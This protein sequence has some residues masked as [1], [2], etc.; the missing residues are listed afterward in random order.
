MKDLGQ[1][2]VARR[3]TIG[4]A[5]DGDADRVGFVDEKG[6]P[7]SSDIIGALL[8]RSVL[9][10]QKG[11][12]IVYDVRSSHS[13]L[14][15]IE[16]NGGTAVREKVG[17]I[18]IRSK[19]RE[20]DA[21][22]GIE[23]SGHFFF[24]ESRFSEGGSLPVFYILDLIQTEQKTLSQLVSEVSKYAHS[25][26]INSEITET[27]ETIYSKLCEKFSTAEID[28]LDGLT[29]TEKDWWI[30]VRPSGTEPL[31]RLNVEAKSKELME[32]MRDRALCIIR[33]SI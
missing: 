25:G 30:N 9:R 5:F 15:E 31:M 26:E 12:T 2:V 29:L 19:M 24:K 4:V 21:V 8:V 23:L 22:L 27:P 17:H 16:K 14:E 18:N 13:L 3:A 28:Y 33:G 10:K 11:A 1:E 32:E 6:T 7:I 20:C